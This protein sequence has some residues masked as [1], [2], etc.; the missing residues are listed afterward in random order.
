MIEK[1][2][3]L[4]LEQGADDVIVSH[5]ES[6]MNHL[7]FV[8]NKI[9][10]TA[11]ETLSTID[12]FV[13]KDKRLAFTTIKDPSED[14]IKKIVDNVMGF[15]QKLEQNE[16]YNGI[17]KGPFTY[18]TIEEGYDKKIEDLDIVDM[19]QKGIM[20][21]QEEGALR[22]SGVIDTSMEEMALT[23]SNGV[24]VMDK[25]SEAY[26]SIRA[27]VNDDASGHMTASSCMATKLDVKG[28]SQKAG[29]IASMAANPIDGKEGVYDIVFDP[30]AF[31]CLLTHI[32]DAA[33]IFSVESGMSFLQ[34]KLGN[35]LGNFSLLDNGIYPNGL[36]S[37]KFDDEGRPTQTTKIIEKGILNTYL[38]NTSTA[39]RY[40]VTPTSNAGIIAPKPNTLVLE[41]KKGKVFDIERGLYVTNVWYTRFQN[42]AKGDFST[43]PRDGIF[44]IENGEITRPVKNIRISDNMLDI[45]K[46]ISLFGKKPVQIKSWE[47]DIPCV[48]PEVLVK[49]VKVTKPHA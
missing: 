32:G 33:S 24:D 8:N 44:L 16:G 4:L 30:M 40:K 13:A 23:N 46:N 12:I 22:C 2:Q 49:N 42:Y 41:G 29:K 20:A 15:I 39:L 5:V 19:V 21:A 43:I 18:P 25:K 9:V 48:L 7:K 45:M 28:A 47:V 26:Y 6:S 14:K 11:S 1:V 36:A 35:S 17:A 34:G 3:R 31:G 10:K 27:L 38:H 37:G